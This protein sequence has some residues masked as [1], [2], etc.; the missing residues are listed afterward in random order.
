[1]THHVPLFSDD[2]EGRLRCPSCGGEYLH[3]TTV[4]VYNRNEDGTHGQRT[5]VEEGVNNY[6]LTRVD[7]NVNGNPSPRRH[8][9][10]VNFYCEECEALPKLLIWQHKGSTGMVFEKE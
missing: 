5:V 6:G 10:V 7:N 9:L 4:E 2:Y 3:H 1:M 8:G